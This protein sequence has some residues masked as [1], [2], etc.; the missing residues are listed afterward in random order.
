MPEAITQTNFQL[1]GQVGEIY[2]GKVADT[3]TIEHERGEL[4]VAVR[5]DRISA[6]DVVLPQPVP[7]KGQ[8][9]NQMSAALLKSTANVVHNWLLDEP[10]PNVSIGLKAEPIQVEMIMRSYL[11]GSAWKAYKELGMRN[12]CGNSLRDFMYEFEPFD[13]A[14]ITPSTKAETGHDENITPRQIV[15]QGLATQAEYDQMAAMATDLFAYGQRLAA[16]RGLVLADT[17][18]EFGRL[19]TGQLIV[20]D[21]VHTPDSSRYFDGVQFNTYLNDETSE[22]P[23]Q[24]SKEFVRE[25]LKEHGFTGEPGQVPPH[26]PSEFIDEVT[27]RYIKLYEIMMREPFDRQDYDDDPMGGIEANIVDGLQRLAA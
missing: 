13:H 21:E 20:I 25:W 11:L 24:L 19:A 6:F 15:E 26:M 9:L 7:Y 12:L 27:E 1:P 23:G 10:D 4:L 5:T 18:Y 2:H 22:R 14:L 8:V 16:E 17:K 3:Y